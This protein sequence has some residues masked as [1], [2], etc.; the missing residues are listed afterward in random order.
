MTDEFETEREDDGR[1]IAEVVTMAG[2]IAYGAT[3]EDAIVNVESIRNLI[4]TLKEIPK[5]AR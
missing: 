5:P 2:V 1:W 3:E 4:S